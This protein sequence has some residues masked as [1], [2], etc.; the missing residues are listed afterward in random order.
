MSIWG[1]EI[2]K[3]EKD[4]VDLL[5]AANLRAD[6]SGQVYIPRGTKFYWDH[7]RLGWHEWIHMPPGQTHDIITI[8]HEATR[9]STLNKEWTD[10][11]ENRVLKKGDVLTFIFTHRKWGLINELHNRDT[12]VSS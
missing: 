4:K 3:E 2:K 1:P 11:A 5:P 10:L 12:S 7:D 9:D 6:A 8:V